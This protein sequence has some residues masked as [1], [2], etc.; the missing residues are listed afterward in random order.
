MKM[1]KQYTF[2]ELNIQFNNRLN[3]KSYILMVNKF[4]WKH[5][6]S[7]KYVFSLVYSYCV[8]Y[9]SKFVMVKNDGSVM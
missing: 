5:F 7:L 9:Y 1:S 4:F 2:T 8:G 6:F 3:V